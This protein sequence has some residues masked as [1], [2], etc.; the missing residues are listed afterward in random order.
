MKLINP[1]ECPGWRFKANLHTHTSISDGV[2]SLAQRIERAISYFFLI[3][4]QSRAN[5]KG[6]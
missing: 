4:V 1:L 6:L 2:L 5:E 3:V